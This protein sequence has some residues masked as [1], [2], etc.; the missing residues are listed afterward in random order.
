MKTIVL[1][2]DGCEGPAGPNQYERPQAR[3][4]TEIRAW[5]RGSGWHRVGPGYDICGD[6]WEAG[7]RGPRLDG[8]RAA[9]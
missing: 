4:V 8:P 9:T 3:T 5:A 2:C 6:C 7:I 1:N